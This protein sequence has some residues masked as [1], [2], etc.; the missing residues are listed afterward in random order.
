VPLSPGG[1]GALPVFDDSQASSTLTA[2]SIGAS[3][4]AISPV[5]SVTL[6]VS[7]LAPQ[8]TLQVS[9]PPPSPTILAFKAKFITPTRRSGRYGAAVD[10]ASVTDEDSLQRAMRRKA[11]LNLE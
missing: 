9:T 6:E 8:P 4:S 11:E 5:S 10:G 2:G 1:F 3:S 7:M